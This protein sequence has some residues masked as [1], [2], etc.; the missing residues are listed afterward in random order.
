MLRLVDIE[1]TQQFLA[2][3]LEFHRS[4]RQAEVQPAREK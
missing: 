1:F 2:T 3:R 4:L